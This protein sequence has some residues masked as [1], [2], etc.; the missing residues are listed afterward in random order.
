MSA[1]D[2]VFSTQKRT[3]F[4]GA[5]P[6]S[7]NNDSTGAVSSDPRRQQNVKNGMRIMNN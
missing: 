6:G 3:T 2:N 7:A 1:L 4:G 5:V